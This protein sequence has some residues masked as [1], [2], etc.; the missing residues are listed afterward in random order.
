MN[1]RVL[2]ANL[3]WF[4]VE[5]P[6]GT[7][8]AQ[9]RQGIRAGSRWPFTR[10]APFLPGQFQFGHY[11]PSPYFK[12]SAA[13]WVQRA[14][15]NAA[16][17]LRDSI[18]RGESYAQFDAYWNANPPTHVIL[19]VGASSWDHD[20]RYI[21]AMKQSLPSVFVAVAGP[22]V[23]ELSKTTEPGLVDAWLL[24]EY[25]K[26]ATRFVNGER[27]V[28][29]FDMLTRDELRQAPFPMFDEE[30]AL[31]YFDAN[32]KG[33]LAPHLQLWGS[34]GCSYKCLSGDTPVNT[35]EGM[36]SIRELVGRIDIGVYT[37]DP[38]EKRAFIVTPRAI[39]KTGASRRLVRVH[40]DDGT[41]I[42]C[43]PDHRFLAFKWGNQFVGEKEWESEAQD[44]KPGMHLRAI[45]PHDSHG[46]IDVSWSR[47]HKEK[48]HRM[49]MEWV[50]GRSLT[51]V[52]EVHHKDRNKSNNRPSNL[53]VC[54]NALEHKSKHPEISQRMRENNPAKNGL[55]PEWA[56]KIKAKQIGKKRS[57]EAKE[58][59]RLA[60]IKRE[61]AKSPEQKAVDAARMISAYMAQEAWKN[62]KPRQAAGAV[63][64]HRV[65][66]VEELEGEHD[67]YCMEIPQTGWFYANNVL[68]H[69]CCFCA[70]PGTM[71]SDDPHGDAPRSV[72]FYDPLWL[73]AFIRDRMMKAELV[74][75]PLRSVYFDDDT[76]NLSDKHILAICE[77]MRRIAL[78]WSMMCRAD[79]SSREVWKAM[80]ESGCFGVKIG[81]ESGSQEV[82]DN[83]VHKK[84]NLK[85]AVETAHW[86]RNELGMTVHGTFTIGLPGETRAQR[87]E[88]IR[89]I[90]N[91]YEHG[92]LDT[93]QLSG[94]A[95][96]PGTP[97]A[98]MATTDPTYVRST[99]GNKKIEEMV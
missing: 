13:A 39:L 51:D 25:E 3:P 53:E 88:T 31:H 76:G 32:P 89:F 72:R 92:A 21:Q 50:L 34:R 73:E 56:A 36:I 11:L 54:A 78:P 29:G 52:E 87:E 99:D 96:I 38:N 77:V 5:N 19:E 1:P 91:A 81:F 80:K 37:Y 35:T 62:R 42:D 58:R 98:D 33:Q 40:F 68:V 43:T 82:I 60:A 17:T 74:G 22:P 70:W 86:L 8:T 9:L 69:N 71:T 79:T 4:T 46:Y 26:P 55:T 47:Y 41:H 20:K 94:T 15:P 63:V 16:V 7:G 10:T 93:H 23:R 95:E 57:A 14:I 66:S 59:Y 48:Q 61:A 24:G 64:N 90:G 49:V 85:E 18:A 97:M 12:Q 28:I 67:T 2:F 83:I 75:S 45:N 44:L 30:V 84:L 27:G 6:C 65:V